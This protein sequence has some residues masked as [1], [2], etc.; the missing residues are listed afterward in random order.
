M[1]LSE[2]SDILISITYSLDHPATPAIVD[3]ITT[4]VTCQGNFLNHLQSSYIA[5]H[6]VSGVLQ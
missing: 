6:S 2:G 4:F 5:C 3:L 1:L